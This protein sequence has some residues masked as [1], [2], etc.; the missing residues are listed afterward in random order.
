MTSGIG[1]IFILSAPSGAGKTTLGRT[2]RETFPFI[3]YSVSHTTRSPR[4]GERDGVDYFFI[5]KR[6]F[7]EGIRLNHWAE[8]ALVHG[9]YYGTSAAYLNQTLEDG[10]DVLLDIDIQGTRQLLDRYPDSITIFVMPPNLK[11]LRKRLETRGTDSPEVIE[12]RLAAAEEEINQKHIY[13]YI[14]INDSLPEATAE[15]C[16]II[17]HHTSSSRKANTESSP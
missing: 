14:V 6:N 12:K 3:R 17:R 5:S 13:R 4:Q 1:H 9:H 10:H 7:E 2:L 16:D 15:L 8:W 11:V